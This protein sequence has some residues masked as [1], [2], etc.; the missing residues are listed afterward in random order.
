MHIAALCHLLGLW[1]VVFI[2]RIMLPL[3][4]ENAS[5]QQ[6]LVR[7][8]VPGAGSGCRNTDGTVCFGLFSWIPEAKTYY[9]ELNTFVFQGVY[10]ISHPCV[11][12]RRLCVSW[13]KNEHDNS[14]EFSAWDISCR[15]ITSH[16]A[17][18]ISRKAPGYLEKKVIV[19]LYF[20]LFS[21]LW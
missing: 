21:L 13:K 20:V 19:I 11:G 15:T 9:F 5:P 4:C 2:V 17:S 3:N 14:P 7:V 18:L 12:S 10:I 16:Q 1:N 8:V 6:H